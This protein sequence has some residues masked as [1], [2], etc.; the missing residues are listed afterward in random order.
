ML[1]EVWLDIGIKKTDTH[2]GVTIKALLD[3]SAI[4]MF[5]V[6]QTS[7]GHISINSL[8]IFTLLMAPK[9]S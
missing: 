4:G 5:I 1:K 9:G 6:L 8:T 7:F 2:E 3:S